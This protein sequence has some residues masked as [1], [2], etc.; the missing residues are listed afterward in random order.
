M[1]LRMSCMLFAA[2]LVAAC[3]GAAEEPAA[4]TPATEAEAS[5]SDAEALDEQLE[6]FV[7]HYNMHHADMVAEL[8]HD[9]AVFLSAD[10]SVNEGR[11]AIEAS[12][13]AAMET[14]SPTLDL[15]VIDRVL[16]DQ[17]AIAMGRWNIEGTPEGADASMMMGGHY[18]SAHQKVGDEWRTM[19][20]ITNYDQEPPPE[21][22][23]GEPPAEEPPESTDSPLAE[24]AEYWVTHYNMHHP[25][26]VASR[27]AE[28]AMVAFANRPLAE[29]REAVA[30]Q[31]AAAIEEGEPEITIH[32]V[33]FQEIGDGWI[34]S[35]GWYEQSTTAGD[36]A[37]AYMGLSRPDAEGNMQIH[38]HVSNGHPVME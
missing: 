31:L 13:A 11:E 29:G 22:P 37:G 21:A 33:D 19:Y 26:M 17:W 36:V 27:Y 6:Y 9:E 7:T 20:V 24:L 25:D 18:M 32:E 4:E 5:M 38:W 10:G 35:G 3:G 30:E 12:M 28:D 16:T 14:M 23:R 8:Y 1:K 34:L 15:E 2:F